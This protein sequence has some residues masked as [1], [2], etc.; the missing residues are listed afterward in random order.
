MVGGPSPQSLRIRRLHSGSRTKQA[1]S[2]LS[3]DPDTVAA[4]ADIPGQAVR[5]YLQHSMDTC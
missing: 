3:S 2:S 4:L 1:P 5:Q